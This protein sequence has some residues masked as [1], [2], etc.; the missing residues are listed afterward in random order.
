[1][2]YTYN[3][4][5]QVRQI[6]KEVQRTATDTYFSWSQNDHNEFREDDAAPFFMSVDDSQYTYLYETAAT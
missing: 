1:M 4:C 2:K 6:R 3:T 5:I